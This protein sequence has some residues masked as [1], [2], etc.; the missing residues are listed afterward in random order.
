MTSVDERLDRRLR[1]LDPAPSADRRPHREDWARVAF[2]SIT[3][4][5]ARPHRRRRPPR[6]AIAGIAATTVTVAAVIGVGGLLLV[7]DGGGDRPEL[8]HQVQVRVEASGDRVLDEAVRIIRSRAEIL[9]I[10]RMDITVVSP[11]HLLIATE[12]GVSEGD[13]RALLRRGDVSVIDLDASAVGDPVA[14]MD[15]AVRRAQKREGLAPTGGDAPSDLPPGYSVAWLE[16]TPGD[17]GGMVLLHPEGAS[18]GPGDVAAVRESPAGDRL[19]T[20][21][22]TD[23]GLDAFREVTREAAVRG[24]VAGNARLAVI[25]D[26]RIVGMPV[27]DWLSYP[28]GM[29][30][31]A[32]VE[33]ELPNAIEARAVDAWARTGPLPEGLTVLAYWGRFPEPG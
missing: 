28:A 11:G 31:R 7:R 6:A 24:R 25:V 5:T 16:P 22:F 9:G 33:F 30:G 26:G 18:V 20:I 4:G 13:I 8:T 21:T 32:G 1:E 23:R 19:A 17:P 15:R 10:E 2:S 3:S 27:V 14:R 12:Q 29:D